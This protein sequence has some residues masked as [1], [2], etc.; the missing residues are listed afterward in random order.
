MV[1]ALVVQRPPDR[2]TRARGAA[3]GA[4]LVLGATIGHEWPLAR[5]T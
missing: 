4:A 5:R 3:I 1:M 2:R